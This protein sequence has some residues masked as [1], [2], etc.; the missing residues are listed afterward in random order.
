MISK[1]TAWIYA[2]LFVGASAGL[3]KYVNRTHAEAWPS[4]LRANIDRV[5]KESLH[6]AVDTAT[7]KLNPALYCGCLTETLEKSGLV[8]IATLQKATTNDEFHSLFSDFLNGPQGADAK[9]SC[10]DKA[11]GR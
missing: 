2:L 5:C 8:A 10:F 4:A 9:L 7:N 6:A 3:W 11:N 1:K